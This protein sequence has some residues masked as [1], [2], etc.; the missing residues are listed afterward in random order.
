[1]KEYP[2][3]IMLDIGTTNIKCYIVSFKGFIISQA[4]ILTPYKKGKYQELN[5]E[6]V[7]IACLRLIKRQ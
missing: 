7:W 4:I 1:M 3:Y 2:F 6:K 5:P